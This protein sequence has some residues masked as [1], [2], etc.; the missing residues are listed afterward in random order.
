[1]PALRPGCCGRHTVAR[2]PLARC[3]DFRGYPA[4]CDWEAGPPAPSSST[5]CA[6]VL[7]VTCRRF[8]SRLDD[9][10]VWGQAREDLPLGLPRWVAGVMPLCQNLTA[11]HLR[12]VELRE[13]PALPLLVHLILEHCV[14]QPALVASLQWLPSLE[15]LHVRGV[16]G[17]GPPAWDVCAC[18][19]LRRIYM[20]QKLAVTLAEAGQ[21]LRLP[22][23]CAVALEFPQEDKWR[24]WLRRLGGRLAELRIPEVPIDAVASH[25]TFMHMPQL[26]Q[27]RHVTLSLADEPHH[28]LC[29]ARL[30]ASLPRSVESLHLKYP[31]LWSE[32]AVV[33]VPS[34]L[35]ALRIKAVCNYVECSEARRKCI[36]PPSER[37]KDLTF[38][39]HGGLERLCLVLW[40]ARVGLQCLDAN[41]P[42]RLRDLNVQA[43]VVHMDARLAAQVA[44]RGRRLACCDAVDERWR[45]KPSQEKVLGCTLWT[46]GVKVGGL[47]VVPVQVVHIGRGPVHME[48]VCG[49]LPKFKWSHEMHWPC[50]CGSCAKCLGPE[51]F[52]GV[53]DAWSYVGAAHK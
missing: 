40:H 9:L 31:H 30:L 39:L 29:V 53:V 44:Q 45:Q 5:G 50:T 6:R 49:Y 2:V 33:V 14:F 18:A 20:S 42:M 17:L 34:S 32:Q 13:V 10:P 52:G 48:Y 26:S 21:E 38:G 35:R 16:W 28:S 24:W 47:S 25:T 12:C 41:A 36:C 46:R 37:T 4:A 43:R 23:A 3:L 22:P 1:M 15:T 11:L 7:R 51:A 27:L 19:R 8:G